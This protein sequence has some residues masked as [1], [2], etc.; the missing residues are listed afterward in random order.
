MRNI[1]H[2]LKTIG[3]Q[4]AKVAALGMNGQ[5]SACLTQHLNQDFRESASIHTQVM[6]QCRHNLGVNPCLFGASLKHLNVFP[7]TFMELDPISSVD[8]HINNA[9]ACLNSRRVELCI[10]RPSRNNQALPQQK[11]LAVFGRNN[12]IRHKDPEKSPSAL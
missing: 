2:D 1:Q 9:R 12:K 8:E 10:R 3:P 11:S 4:N 7:R 6:G 5:M